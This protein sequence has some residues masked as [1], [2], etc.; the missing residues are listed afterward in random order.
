MMICIDWD[1]DIRALIL[2]RGYIL[3]FNIHVN[4][5]GDL[6]AIELPWSKDA[7]LKKA[8]G[9]LVI[10]RQARLSSRTAITMHSRASF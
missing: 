3:Y 7:P 4:P 9:Y 1:G 2:A 10:P 6:N 5:G 8:A